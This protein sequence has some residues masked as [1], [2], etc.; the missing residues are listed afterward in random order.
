M[1][2]EIEMEAGPALDAL[3]AEK[4]FGWKKTRGVGGLTGYGRDAAGELRVLPAYSTD[5]AA[6]YSVLVHIRDAWSANQL[7]NFRAHLWKTWDARHRGLMVLKSELSYEPG[8]YSRAALAA[9]SPTPS[10]KEEG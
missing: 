6:D 7:K 4:V 1:N 8:D 3:V 2:S 10:Q 5:I 9:L